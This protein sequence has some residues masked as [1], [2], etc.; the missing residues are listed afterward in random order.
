[1]GFVL[2]AGEAAAMIAASAANAE[3]VR[4]YLAGEDLNTRP[5]VSPARWVIDFRDWPESRARRYAVPFSHVDAYVRPVRE[6]V[7]RKAHRERWW[8]FGDLR[9]ALYRALAPVDRCI[10]IT[11][12]SKAVQPELIASDM[13]FSHGIA[14]FTYEDNEH[15]GLLSSGLHWSW[16]VA[17]GSTL[18]AE[19][20]GTVYDP[21]QDSLV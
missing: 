13:V 18:G 10:A 15:F 8:Q 19:T 14:V 16:A 7:N 1:M 5:D 3:V 6:K 11:M 20:L 17:R 2:S 4:P 9:P 21:V 12:H